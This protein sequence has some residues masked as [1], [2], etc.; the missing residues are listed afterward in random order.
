MRAYTV[1][2][3]CHPEAYEDYLAS[4][5]AQELAAGNADSAVCSDCHGNHDIAP[6]RADPA[7]LLIEPSVTRCGSCHVEQFDA[8][9]AS[10]HGKALLERGDHEMPA[11]VDCHGIHAMGQAS[12]PAFRKQSPYM[13]AG[14]HADKELMARR[15]LSTNIMETYVADFHGAT[16]ALFAAD[17]SRAPEQA[18]CIDCH[19]THD[20]VGTTGSASPM[21]QSKLVAVCQECHPEAGEKFPAAWIGHYAPT[22]ERAAPVFWVRA[23]YTF[24]LTGVV[25]A[26]AAHV[27]LD[28]WRVIRDARRQRSK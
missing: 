22:P 13:C 20:I 5:H 11:C 1:C 8:Y 21:L 16:T 15:G 7:A 3:S 28:M 26:L 2:G 25:G 4:S 9:R 12:T 23:I 27:G 6:A 10:V 17:S 24:I 18:V 14:C 19:G